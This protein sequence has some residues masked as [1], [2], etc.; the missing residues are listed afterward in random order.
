[1][2]NAA[3]HLAEN[4]YR[5]KVTNENL[6][7]CELYSVAQESVAEHMKFKKFETRCFA[8]VFAYASNDDDDETGSRRKFFHDYKK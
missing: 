4:E 6:W 3:Q 1:M 5:K 7:L 2:H 8:C